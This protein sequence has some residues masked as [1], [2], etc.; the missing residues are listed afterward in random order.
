MN[1]E[2]RSAIIAATA[3]SLLSLNILGLL[4]CSPR[5]M[6]M[7]AADLAEFQEQSVTSTEQQDSEN[8]KLAT[9]SSV[10]HTPKDAF[11]NP[12]SKASAH[13][14]PIGSGA[15]YASDSDASTRSWTQSTT[16][17]INSG[18][19]W[20][21]SVAQS[22][23]KDRTMTVIGN[24]T[25]DPMV[26]LPINIPIPSGF[27]PKVVYNANGCT[28]GVVVIF[29]SVLQKPHQLRQYNWNNGRPTAGQYKTWN[30][31]GLGHG[32]KPGDRVGTSASGVA[33]LFG[34]LR[35][36]EINTSGHRI[37]HALQMVM[38]RTPGCKQMLSKK[39]VPP[40]VSTDGSAGSPKNNL[41]HIPYGGLMAIPPTV[42]LKAL[43]LSEPGLRLAEA[44]RDYG[45]YAVDGGG[46]QN[47]AIRADQTLT[48]ATISALKKDIPKFYK[49]LRLV[50]NNNLSDS[51]AGGGTPRA[52]NCG[53]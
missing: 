2:S 45:V 6:N 16:F 46:C 7:S 18:A 40:A 44:L 48:S 21:V 51:V 41:G 32:S 13:H 43:G 36:R 1:L 27:A 23:N 17:G 31:R 29:D 25:C 47:P 11:I 50:T 4:A 24:A 19:P 3:K 53:H 14:R 34:V 37:E 10:C 12:F 9:S 39:F 33:A 20:G 49:H 5:P 15:K 42:N 35:G 30:V 8:F 28:D 26:G 22:T 52:P 38:P